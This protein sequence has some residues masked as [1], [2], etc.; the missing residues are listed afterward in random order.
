MSTN[1]SINVMGNDGNIRSIYLHWDGYPSHALETLK[2]HYNS[3]EQAEKLIELGDCSS[4]ADTLDGSTFYHRD[5]NEDWDDV[6]PHTAKTLDD[7]LS[8]NDQQYNYLYDG[9]GWGII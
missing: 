2:E 4:L 8:Y 5:R 9:N 7:A 1:A 3:Q 6:Q